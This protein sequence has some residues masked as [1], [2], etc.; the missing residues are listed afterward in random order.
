MQDSKQKKN[1]LRFVALFLLGGVINLAGATPFT[2]INS[3]L[4]CLL[5]VIYAGLILFWARSVRERL[6]PTKARSY[7]IAAATMMLIYLILRIVKYRI[8]ISAVTISRYLVYLYWVP[9]LFI[10]TMFLMTCICIRYGEQEYRQ[11]DEKLLLIPAGVLSLLA[12][13]NDFHMLVYIPKVDLGIFILNTGTY[14]HGISFYLL[15]GWI[16]FLTAAG[17]IMLLHE[18]GK[19]E[20]NGNL[21][22]FAIL[23]LWMA[24]LLLNELVLEKIYTRRMFNIPEIHIFGMLAVF[25]CCIRDRLIPYNEN[26]TGFF[27]QLGFPVM[28]TD[29]KMNSVYDTGLPI[30]ASVQQLSLSLLTP[31]H[32]DEDTRLSGMKLRAG[33]AFWT[34]DERKQN[35]E[36]RHLIAAN[37]IL[38]Q[39][40]DL[41]AAENK[42]KGSKAQ[43]EAQSLIYDR[44]ADALYPK[45][46]RIAALLEK[47]GPE[48][49]DF[50]KIL[51]ECCVLNAWSKRKGNLLLLTENTLPTRN[52][53]LFLALQESAMYLRCYGVEA[54]AVGTEYADFSL[55]VIH[56]LYDVFETLVESLLPQMKKMTVS[57]TADGIRMAMEMRDKLY[58]PDTKLHIDHSRSD[59]VDFLTIHAGEEEDSV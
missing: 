58:L 8:T 49:D 17:I 3:I 53:E 7:M 11:W 38:D 10:P 35:E 22:P 48:A 25:E 9:Q 1:T 37:E 19:R 12:L 14:N 24:V 56:D 51:A 28:I 59:G 46:Q 30:K 15:Y 27:S 55:P 57:L 29:L 43:L 54:A 16:V 52:R 21:N 50:P 2:T 42:L 34:E 40:N 20:I 33:F 23:L 18:E 45:Q 4:F 47:T 6:L 5:F 32:I 13:T 26:Y 39:E 44:I 36:N 31:V 41:I